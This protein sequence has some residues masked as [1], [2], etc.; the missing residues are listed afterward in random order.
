M[1]QRVLKK[2]W[3]LFFFVFWWLGP[4]PAPLKNAAGFISVKKHKKIFLVNLIH[5]QIN[6]SNRFYKKFSKRLSLQT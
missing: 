2:I 6:S 3:Y 4:A 1:Q 5:F